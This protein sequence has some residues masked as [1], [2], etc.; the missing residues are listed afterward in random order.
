MDDLITTRFNATTTATEAAAGL[1]LSGT[2]AVVTGASS[3]IGLE[4]ARVLA[5]AGANV[6]LAVR[7]TTA[8]GRAA[9]DITASHPNAS[10]DVCPLD[11]L[12]RSSIEA[13]S[14]YWDGPLHLLINNAGV[15]GFP[16]LQ[17]TTTGLEAQFATNHLGH[18][19]LSVGLHAP[20]AAA[21][22][23]RVV[24]LSSVA[25]RRSSVV[26]DDISFT[27]RPYD[28]VLAYG[29]SKTANILFAVQATHLWA[30][31][32]ITAN[33]V[34]PG[35]I[36]ETGLYRHLDSSV[37]DNIATTYAQRTIKQGASTTVV[38][39]TAPELDG[40][41]GRYFEDCNEAPV[42]ELS[43]LDAAGPGVAR[44]ALDPEAAERLWAASQRLLA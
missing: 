7:D 37:V 11:L 42:L 13:F 26:F 41:G 22:G 4:S 18:F 31:D 3:G 20:L 15:M 29:Q 21:Q 10:V 9:L 35:P 36:V 34:H 25:H 2:R 23:A 38:V 12:D 28:P 27:N 30:S 33:A 1:D 5:A 24:S 6:T 39:A 16:E 43:A 14:R 32:G 8:G 44:Y 40:V 17:T 19:A